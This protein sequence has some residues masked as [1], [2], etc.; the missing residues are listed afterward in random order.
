[1]GMKVSIKVPTWIENLLSPAQKMPVE[2]ASCDGFEVEFFQFDSLFPIVK[3]DHF[4]V[5][6][7]F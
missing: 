3:E 1:M 6:F 2:F 4:S 5:G 7:K